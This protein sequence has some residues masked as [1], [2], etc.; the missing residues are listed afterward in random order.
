MSFA[1]WAIREPTVPGWYW[2]RYAV[3]HYKA[4]SWHEPHP[5]VVAVVQDSNGVFNLYMP[6]TDCVWGFEDLVVAE[7]AGPL[8]PPD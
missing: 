5:I 7:W 2:L 4:G 6:G 3:F 8:I 1:Q